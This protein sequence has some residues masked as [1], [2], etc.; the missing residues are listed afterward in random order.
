[1][2][3]EDLE[4]AARTEAMTPERLPAAVED[5]IGVTERFIAAR[6]PQFG[7]GSPVPWADQAQRRAQASTGLPVL[8]HLS[9]LLAVAPPV[10]RP[11]VRALHSAGPLLGWHQTYSAEQVGQRF[12]E[13]YGWS[14]LV[15]LGGP[16]PG[17]EFAAGF[18]ILGPDIDYPPHR[19]E[20]LELYLPL[21]GRASWWR[22][23]GWHE[24]QPGETVCHASWEAHAMRTGGEPLLALYLWRSKNIA[25][26]AELIDP[27]EADR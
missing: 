9:R 13:H 26:H 1:M 2:N 10:T 25:Q 6:A 17:T 14:E 23:G 27:Q 20:A 24:A 3:P 18:L 21:A 4:A 8:C 19:H 11:L 15:G 7:A 16:V 22:G 5:L 12:L